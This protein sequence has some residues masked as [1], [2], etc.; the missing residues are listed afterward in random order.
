MHSRFAELP[1]PWEAL[2]GLDADGYEIRHGATEAADEL[3]AALP[4]GLGWVSGPLLA[5][6]LHGSFEN[7]AV[8]RAIT[9]VESAAGSGIDAAIDD[10]AAKTAPHLDLDAITALVAP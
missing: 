7:A 8:T 6:Y 1:Q 10:L 5:L 3:D 2:C 4:D 9:G